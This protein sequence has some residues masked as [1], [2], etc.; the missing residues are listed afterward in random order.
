[1]LALLFLFHVVPGSQPAQG[2]LGSNVVVVPSPSFDGSPRVVHG[3]EPVHVQAVVPER[4]VEALDEAVLGGLARLNEVDLDPLRVGP[5][6]ERPARELRA[7]VRDDDLR[8][9]PLHS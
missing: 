1:M 7:V 2:A 9:A 4:A 6:I 5:G 3:E 8:Q